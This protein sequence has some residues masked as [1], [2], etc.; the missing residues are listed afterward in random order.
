MKTSDRRAALSRRWERSLQLPDG[1]LAVLPR[2]E[3]SGNRRLLLEGC[4]G[5]AEYD[6]G[7]ICLQTGLGIVRLTGD[8]LCLHRLNP[9]CAVITGRF[10]SLEF[11]G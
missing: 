2:I 6:E 10:V 7:C 5:I 11:L 4:R 8:T 1:S 9:D 3:L